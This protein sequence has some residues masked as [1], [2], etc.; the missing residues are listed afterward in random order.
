MSKELNQTARKEAE[1]KW[2]LV[3][4][5]EVLLLKDSGYSFT[6]LLSNELGVDMPLAQEINR[7]HYTT[8]DV[9]YVPEGEFIR[10]LDEDLGYKAPNNIFSLFA[11]AYKKQV[12]PNTELLAFLKQVRSQGIKTAILSNTIAI[13]EKAQEEA[14]ISKADGF[15]PI[16]YSWEVEMLKPNRNIFE[17]A[18]EKL[19]ARPEDIVFID[20]KEEHLKGARQVGL[21]TVLFDDTE[22][23]I[24]RIKSLG[25]LSKDDR[26]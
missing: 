22:S 8:M 16:L 4:I 11:N 23:T 2:L 14:G 12:R 24:A 25:I 6:E 3:D 17:L 15:D 5:G 13:Y 18:V 9:K 7:A 20:D 21:R 26:H 10:R 19:G 1:I